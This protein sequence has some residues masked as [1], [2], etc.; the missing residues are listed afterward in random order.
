MKLGIMQPY[1]FSYLG[2]F[3]SIN[4]VDK[5]V[6]YDDVQFI[7]GGW[8]NRNRILINGKESMLTLK[9]KKDDFK[10][11]INER[12]LVDNYEY[13][14]NKI[15][16]SIELAYSKAPYFKEIIK[17]IKD[18]FN[19]KENNLSQ[20][21]VNSIIKICNYLDITTEIILSSKLNK[22]NT[23]KNQCKVI[24]INKILGANT[25]INALGGI[26]LYSR[27][28]FKRNEIDLFFLKM[29]DIVYKQFDENNF[30]PNLSIIDVL[31]FNSKEQVKK[32]LNEYELV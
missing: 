21:I 18:I 12:Y 24:H 31:M 29:N 20:F 2:Y 15:I 6:I 5:F 27:E 7:K 23:L 25:Y 16:K 30:I 26:E 13:E 22:D 10:L 3:Q 4:A 28:V 14:N 8:I 17:L 32:M 11:N 19:F 1:L 9:I